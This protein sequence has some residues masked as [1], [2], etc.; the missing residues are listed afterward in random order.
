MQ[1]T[2][3]VVSLVLAA[4]VSAKGNGGNSIKSQCSQ[5]E[6]L[7]K[8]SQLAANETKLASKFDNN[9]TAIDA[10]KAKV[11]DKA[12]QLTAM[13]SNTTLMDACAPIQA[14]A[15]DVNQCDA[16]QKMEKMVATAANQTKLESKFEVGV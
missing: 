6:K 4:A 7:A 12:T 9:Q 13:M 15:A 2:S 10:F 5:M 16:I 3:V 11:A 8:Q 1:L 14:H